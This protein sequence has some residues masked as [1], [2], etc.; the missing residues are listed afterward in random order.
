MS[1][2]KLEAAEAM[3]KCECGNECAISAYRRDYQEEK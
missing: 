2:A 1:D 3:S